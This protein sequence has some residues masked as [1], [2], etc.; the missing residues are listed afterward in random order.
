MRNR[1]G[2][3]RGVD[4]NC[5]AAVYKECETKDDITYLFIL[6]ASGDRRSWTM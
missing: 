6:C 2:V 1:Y 4:K 5:N 3:R